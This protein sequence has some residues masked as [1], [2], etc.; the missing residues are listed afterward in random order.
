MHAWDGLQPLNDGGWRYT[1]AEG[2]W[3]LPR[4]QKQQKQAWKK[5]RTAKL[6]AADNLVNVHIQMDI[7]R[8]SRLG[9]VRKRGRK[10]DRARREKAS[11]REG[12]RLRKARV[13]GAE[14]K[15]GESEGAFPRPVAQEGKGPDVGLRIGC[16]VNT[17]RERDGSKPV[18]S[19]TLHSAVHHSEQASFVQFQEKNRV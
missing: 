1:K 19:T 9:G 15:V 6:A 5:W 14:R 8:V 12:T 10:R 2:D 3:Q 18:S 7:F 17:K 4:M 16:G 11:D 13:G